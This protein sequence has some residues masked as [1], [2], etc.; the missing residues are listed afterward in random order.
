LDF[1]F[2]VD[3]RNSPKDVELRKS[4][5]RLIKRGHLSPAISR[6]QEIEHF[7]RKFKLSLRENV[8]GKAFEVLKIKEF[9]FVND[10][11][12]NENNAEFGVFSQRL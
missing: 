12:K 8:K 10:C 6:V 9:T 2:S 3:E 1:I 11:F 4:A 7:E 5:S